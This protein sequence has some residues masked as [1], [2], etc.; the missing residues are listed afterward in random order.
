MKYLIPLLV[1][2]T[3][4][5]SDEPSSK[6]RLATYYRVPDSL[7][8]EVEECTKMMLKE[9]SQ[10]T[11]LESSDMNQLMNSSHQLC[12]KNY[13]RGTATLERWRE[14]LWVMVDPRSLSKAERDTLAD[15]MWG[16]TNIDQHPTP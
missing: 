11:A 5:G 15:L 8:T 7:S 10:R 4:C 14:G 1:L 3:A 16:R 2:L 12:I 13:S 9:L 6:Y